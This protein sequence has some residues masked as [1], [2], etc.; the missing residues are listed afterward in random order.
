[1]ANQGVAAVGEHAVTETE[2]PPVPTL[3]ELAAAA[4]AEQRERERVDREEAKARADEARRRVAQAALEDVAASDLG[5]WFPRFRWEFVETD[6]SGPANRERHVVRDPDTGLTLGVSSE[7]QSNKSS[8]TYHVQHLTAAEPGP[9]R[10]AGNKWFEAGTVRSAAE[11]GLLIEKLDNPPRHAGV[12]G[13]PA[14]SD[15]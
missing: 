7:R 12:L 4:L 15:G 11:V 10:H 1:M 3:R 13:E 8:L 5:R 6:H 14:A 2:G 9:G